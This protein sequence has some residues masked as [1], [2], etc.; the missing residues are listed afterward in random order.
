MFSGLDSESAM[1]R[2]SGGALSSIGCLLTLRR[3]RQLTHAFGV[4]MWM[5]EFRLEI[6]KEEFLVMLPVEVFLK[7]VLLK[8]AFPEESWWKKPL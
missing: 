7:V 1:D 8:V 5:V 4:L 6:G 3:Q 2:V